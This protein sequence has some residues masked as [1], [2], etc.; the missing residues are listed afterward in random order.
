[1]TILIADDDPTNLKLLR[2]VLE[3]DGYEVLEADDGLNA[4]D[5]LDQHHVDAVISDILMPR[6]DGYR[7][8]SAVRNRES[9]NCLPF[10]IYTATYRSPGDE[11][12]SQ[13]FGADKYLHKP[14]SAKDILATLEELFSN[15]IYREPRLRHVEHQEDVMQEYSQALVRKLEEQNHALELARDELARS[16]EA[17]ELRVKER[18]AELRAANEE[19]DAFSH[20]A[21]HDLR[22][23]LRAINGYCHILEEDYGDVL[24][25][26]GTAALTRINGL[27]QKMSSLIEK[28]LKLSHIGRSSLSRSEVDFSA[29]VLTCLEELQQ[30]DPGRNA[31]MLV[32]PGMTVQADAGLL[33]IALDNLI[34]NCWKFTSKVPQTK[35]E[36]GRTHFHGEP[37]FFVRDNGAGFDPAFA[38]RLFK[39]FIRMHADSEFPGTGLGLATVHRI[40]TRHGGRIWAE[41]SVNQGATFYIALAHSE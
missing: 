30:G 17:L 3:A 21:A 40:V 37:V 24:G 1:M 19:L 8:C 23:P 39:P 15:P 34:G 10:V 6:M 12:L 28:L 5:V 22:S 2:A 25:T 7:L 36:V 27:T 35:I 20:S 4:L 13:A 32:E 38:D 16:N 14:A 33:K 31:E 26:E 41:S 9:I 29:L 18:T 11:K